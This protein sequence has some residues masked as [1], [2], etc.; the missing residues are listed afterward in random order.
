MVQFSYKRLPNLLYQQQ[1]P[2]TPKN[3][4]LQLS[5]N[6]LQLFGLYRKFTI[7]CLAK[8]S[9]WNKTTSP[10]KMFLQRVWHEQHQGNSVYQ[11]GLCHMISVWTWSLLVKNGT[12]RCLDQNP[13]CTSTWKYQQA[14]IN[15][16]Q[17]PTPLWSHYT[18]D[19]LFSLKHTI[20]AGWPIMIQDIPLAIQPYWKFHEEITIEN[21]LLF[22]GNRIFIQ[23]CQRQA[24]FK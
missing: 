1:S 12:T 8:K 16:K 2:A 15:N 14:S 11:K 5:L 24:L 13:H 7:S 23:S 21:V 20:Q 9:P 18:N 10:W 17:N 6:S 3:T 19:N 4:H 22:Q